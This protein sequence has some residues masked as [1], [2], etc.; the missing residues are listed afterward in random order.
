MNR[1]IRIIMGIASAI[2]FGIEILIGMFAH[3]WVRL[4]LGDVLVVILLYTICRTVSPE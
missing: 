4:Q 1:R 3:G 2:L